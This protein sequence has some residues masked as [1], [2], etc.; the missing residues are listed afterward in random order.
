[1][2]ACAH[3]TALYDGRC[4]VANEAKGGD[5]TVAILQFFSLR[6]FEMHS[7]ILAFVPGADSPAV[8]LS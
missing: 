8:S 3:H 6:G 7:E 2:L 4:F 1:M 5:R